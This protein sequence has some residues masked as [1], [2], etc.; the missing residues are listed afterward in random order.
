MINM[1]DLFGWLLVSGMLDDDELPYDD[2]EED[3]DEGDF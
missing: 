2:D 3:E 1:N